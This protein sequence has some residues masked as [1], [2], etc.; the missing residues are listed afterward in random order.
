MIAAMASGWRCDARRGAK[1]E[2]AWNTHVAETKDA[3]RPGSC[4]LHVMEDRQIFLDLLWAL[5]VDTLQGLWDF[6]KFY[7]TI[8]PRSCSPN[9]VRTGTATRSSPSPMLVHFAPMLLKP[10]KAAEG[11]TESRSCGIVAGCGRSGSMAR[12]LP[13]RSLAKLRPS[14]KTSWCA[15]THWWTSRLR[16]HWFQLQQR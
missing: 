5:G 6:I 7:D 3:A 9:L 14:F 2:R 12:G 10:G 13:A 15:A 16:L 11:P 1:E 4:C 8:D